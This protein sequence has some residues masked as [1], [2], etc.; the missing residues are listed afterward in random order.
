MILK[1]IIIKKKK[2]KKILFLK[3]FKNKGK[4]YLKKKIKKNE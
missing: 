4:T 3:V 1:K 2:K